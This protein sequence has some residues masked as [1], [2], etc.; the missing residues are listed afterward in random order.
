M[1]QKIRGKFAHCVALISLTFG[2]FSPSYQ[3]SAV[4]QSKIKLVVR[5]DLETGKTYKWSLNCRPNSG[6]HPSLTSTCN[7]LTSNAGRKIFN[8][9]PTSTTCLQIFGGDSK[10][11]ITGTF[12]S[13]K[14]SVEM[15]R[16]DGC[17]IAQWDSL[18]KVVRYR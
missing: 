9:Q 17:R 11:K 7:F 2:V 13:K 5:V 3:A 1:G 8:P 14:I 6:T 4:A 12:Y 18:I 10:A 16:R 15:D